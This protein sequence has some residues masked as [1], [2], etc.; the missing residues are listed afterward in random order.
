MKSIRDR[1]D[2]K[3]MPE[4]NSGCWLWLGNIWSKR[5]GY[6]R[7]CVNGK[8]EKAHRVSWSLANGQIPS[9]AHV[10]HSCD[11][12]YCVNP[13]HLYLGDQARNNLD[14]DE[15]GRQ[16]APRGE[17]NG[18][19]RLAEADI[20]AIRKSKLS[21][22]DIAP[23]FGVDPSTIRTIRRRETWAHVADDHP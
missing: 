15:R 6:G 2:E 3:W 21:S 10:L 14:R 12:S 22:I 23:T 16:V 11:N 4:P 8:K 5:L 19:A 17:K 9:D 7:F 20:I 1:F 13:Q 18:M